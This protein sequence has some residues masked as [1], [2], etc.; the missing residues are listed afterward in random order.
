[1]ASHLY[2]HGYRFS[3]PGVGEHYYDAVVVRSLGGGAEEGRKAPGFV[4]DPNTRQ[5]EQTARSSR[6][7][8]PRGRRSPAYGFRAVT[9]GAPTTTSLLGH[10]HPAPRDV[11]LLVSGVPASARPADAQRVRG[12]GVPGHDDGGMI[13]FPV[14]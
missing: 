11:C 8:T 2:R 7:S 5:Q 6:A 9:A 4:F 10:K 3:V 12:R 1:M 13:H 14:L